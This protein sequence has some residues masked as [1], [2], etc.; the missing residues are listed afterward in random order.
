MMHGGFTPICR[1]SLTV[2]AVDGNK[3]QACAAHGRKFW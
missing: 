1:R 3:L 2:P